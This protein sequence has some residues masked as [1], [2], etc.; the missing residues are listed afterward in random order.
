M[1]ASTNP[2]GSSS[3]DDL[4]ARATAGDQDAWAALFHECFP[5]V[6][7]AVRQRIKG[8]LRRY[9]DSTDIFNDAVQRDYN[10]PSVVAWVPLNESWGVPLINKGHV[11]QYAFV[12]RAVRTTRLYDYYRPV[13]DNDGW[14]HTDVTD[15]CTIHDYTSSGDE[16]RERYAEAAVGGPLP[17]QTWWDGGLTF[18]GG[19]GYHG[20]PV[21]LTEVGGYLIKP[22]WLPREQWDVLYASYGAVDDTDE[23]LAKIEDLMSAIASLPFVSGFCYTQLT[24]VEQEINGLLTYDREPKVPVERM[25][26]INDGLRRRVATAPREV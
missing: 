9:V 17:E 10:A 6:R 4:F 7:R 26:A 25:K 13:I 5:K 22:F 23:L 24:D 11:G 19:S 21:M 2:T 20:Q 3:Q 8:P 14:D 12:E 16:V 18:V 1:V 15:I